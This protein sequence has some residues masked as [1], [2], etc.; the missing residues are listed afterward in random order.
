MFI[1]PYLP[2]NQ[3]GIHLLQLPSQLD[4]CVS[5]L[6]SPM[7]IQASISL[8]IPFFYVSG[9]LTCSNFCSF[10]MNACNDSLPR[11]ITC[12][13]LY[14]W[15]LNDPARWTSAHFLNSDALEFATLR[16][17]KSVCDELFN[18]YQW[19]VGR[20]LEF[21]LLISGTASGWYYIENNWFM[22]CYNDTSSHAYTQLFDT[23]TT[24]CF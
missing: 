6:G 11:N 13:S 1:C 18:E 4:H 12:I 9:M 19:G 10:Y 14:T 24:K 17:L 20:V 8:L 21:S 16:S 22:L 7:V 2:N 5:C 15:I 3:T 23:F